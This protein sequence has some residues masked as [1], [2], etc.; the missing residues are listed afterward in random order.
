MYKNK[1]ELFNKIV[2]SKIKYR[3]GITGTPFVTESSLFRIINFLTGHKF[4]NERISNSPYIQDQFMKLFLKNCKIDMQDYQWPE[5]NIHNVLIQLDITQQTFYD[6][7][8]NMSND[9][10]KLRKLVCDINLMFNQSDFKT[11]AELKAYGMKHYKKIYDES[12]VTLD[13]L[14]SQLAN[15]NSNQHT[16]TNIEFFRRIEHFNYLI[17]KQ[18]D[19]TE[20]YRQSYEYFMK[21]IEAITTNSTETDCIICYSTFDESTVIT[22]IKTCGHYFCKNCCDRIKTMN[23]LTCPMCRKQANTN[24][25]INVSNVTEI[26]NSSKISEI[27]NIVPKNGDKIIIFTQFDK[28]IDKIETFLSRNNITSSTYGNYTNEQILLLSSNNNAEGIDLTQFDKMI[29]FEPFEN[30]MFCD[31]VEKQLIA[32]IHRIGRTKPVDIYRFIT[33][34]TIEEEIYNQFI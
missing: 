33:Q 21:N 17:Q 9:T 8:K 15:I 22:Y 2:Q 19:T 1:I 6:T 20:K 13:Q 5:L 34:G 23:T 16:F 30:N 24:D 7:E 4:N 14:K 32:R 25:I 31:Q 29:I 26:N 28:I 27:L 3:W 10:N 12:L 11:P 18:S